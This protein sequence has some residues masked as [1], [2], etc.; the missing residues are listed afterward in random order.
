[1]R[2]EYVKVARVQIKHG[3]FELRS[4]FWNIAS[5]TLSCS[6]GCRTLNI[7]DIFETPLARVNNGWKLCNSLASHHC[8][9]STSKKCS[10]YPQIA[11]SYHNPLIVSSNATYRVQSPINPPCKPTNPHPKD[12]LH[13][14]HSCHRCRP[15]PQPNTYHYIS[16]KRPILFRASPAMVADISDVQGDSTYL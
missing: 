12:I 2:R 1:M 14:L 5:L 4:R 16:P 11:N 13:S 3:N 8:D 10:R 15:I 9:A 6:S 7:L